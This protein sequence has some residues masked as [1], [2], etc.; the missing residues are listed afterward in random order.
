ME[1]LNNK[2]FNEDCLQGMKKIPDKY[3]DMILCDL[4]YGSTRNVWDK[5]IDLKI[6]W[7]NYNRII[8]DNGAIIL[9]SQTPFDKILGSSNIKMLRY[10]YIWEK[11]CATGFLNANKMPLKKHENILVFYKKL[12]TYNIQYNEGKPYKTKN[13]NGVSCN[14]DNKKTRAINNKGYRY[15]L[16]IL[17]FKKDKEKLHPTQ[18]PLSLCEFFIKTY[19]NENEIVLDNCMGSGTTAIACINLKRIYIGYEN[20]KNYFELSNK[21]I[22][23]FIK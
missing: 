20:N 4:P 21:R 11:T 18:K 17:K 1:E 12:P 22:G 7:E 16:S 2:I 23:Q 19:T 10:E 13:S 14:Y 9:F 6:L 15:P 5:S 8:K 3:I